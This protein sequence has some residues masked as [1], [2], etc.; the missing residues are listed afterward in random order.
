MASPLVLPLDSASTPLDLLG[1]LA[2]LPRVAL[3]ESA[4]QSPDLGRY[5]YLTADPVASLTTGAS[6]WASVRDRLRATI[7]HDVPRDPT[8]PPFQG[9]WVGWFGYE[10]GVA[11]D[12]MPTAPR[13]DLATP[14]IALSLYDW[15]IA[16]DHAESTA[17]LI[18]SGIDA[19]GVASEARAE[20]RAVDVM[21]WL[22][23][24]EPTLPRWTECE[25]SSLTQVGVAA[26]GFAAAPVGLT[27]DFTPA[28]Y[29]DAVAGVIDQILDGELFQ[30]N[31]SQRFL[32]P[33][34]GDPVALYAAM[35]RHAAAP[36][37]AC[38][39]QPDRWVL[40]ASPELFFRLDA[41]SGVVE[42]RPIK[43][44]RPRSSDATGDAALAL[45]LTSSEKDRAENVMIV[46]LLRNDLSR[47]CLPES[48]MVPELC[49]L[50]SHS[51]VHHL[52][53]IVTGV[54][55]PECDVADLIA[56][57]FPGGSITGAP[58]LRATEVIAALEPV[59]RGVYCGA[60]GWVGRDGSA[61]L[62]IAIRTVTLTGGIV[63]VH[64]G[65][66]ITAQSDPDE[67]YRETLDKARALVAA[68]AEVA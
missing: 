39:A 51:A 59:T 68:I 20:R 33:Y 43:G 60:I 29:R 41:A 40:S 17:C 66:G 4:T 14:D 49:S 16:W 62:S 54:L 8:L 55:Q 23:H 64:A 47:V 32:A 45:A 34:R 61:A 36:M 28:Q 31:L 6:E 1:R 19:H 44:T 27:G 13:N 56:A 50:E 52:V 3:L 18:S 58:K 5:S 12:R 35:R 67:E 38:L 24:T 48:V 26:T 11:F 42:T 2:A 65:G 30:A 46:D 9:G 15:V 10:F 37:A 53:S 25:S 63:A 21:G 57:T 22:D 7:A